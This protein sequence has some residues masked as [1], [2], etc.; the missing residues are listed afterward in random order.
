MDDRFEYSDPSRLPAQPRV[1]V[2]IITYNQAAFVAETITSVVAQLT[3]FPFEVIVADDHSSDETLRIA[4]GLQAK[5]PDRVRVV[6]TGAN[7]GINPNLLFALGHA[8]GDY[9]AICE[10]DDFWTDPSKLQR[11]FEAL[12]Q[13]RKVDLAICAGDIRK[14]GVSVPHVF[15]PYGNRERIVSLEELFKGYGW[16][17]P[18]AS[19]F[20]RSSATAR[21]PGWFAAAPFSDFLLV[22]AGASRGGAFY[23]PREMVCYRADTP[24]SFSARSAAAPPAQTIAYTAR[25]YRTMRDGADWFGVPRRLIDHRLADFRLIAARAWCKEGRPLR[26]ALELFRLPPGYVVK[27][28]GRMLSP[29]SRVSDR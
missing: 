9:L 24:T 28:V 18:T 6:H 1:S 14:N 10:G 19:L 2:L 26:A 7:K 4:A 5:F 23:S 8:R 13:H 11:Q 22:M 21:L 15:W 3:N 25:A 12:E 16:P 17:A 20:W 27:R 29:G